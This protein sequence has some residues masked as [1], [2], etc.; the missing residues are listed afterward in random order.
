MK[1]MLGF[2]SYCVGCRYTQLFFWA[3]KGDG[4]S[5]KLIQLNSILIFFCLYFVFISFPFPGG[6]C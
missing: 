5:N 1:A 6:P 4:L 2:V 3:M